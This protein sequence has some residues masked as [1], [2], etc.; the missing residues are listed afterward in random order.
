MKFQLGYFILA[1]HPWQHSLCAGHLHCNSS[2]RDIS[3]LGELRVHVVIVWNRDIDWSEKDV[4][5]TGYSAHVWI[6]RLLFARSR[7]LKHLCAP[8]SPEVPTPPHF[9]LTSTF[10][11]FCPSPSLSLSLPMCLLKWLGKFS[12]W[13]KWKW[14]WRKAEG[15]AATLHRIPS[16]F[17][18]SPFLIFSH[19]S[20]HSPTITLLFPSYLLN[21]SWCNP[22]IKSSSDRN[23]LLSA[24]ITHSYCF[25][26]LHQIRLSFGPKCVRLRFPLPQF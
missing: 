8:V 12:V 23:I 10:F 14:P 11:H 17:F 22:S 19:V 20:L 1:D 26:N 6:P 15:S 7:P 2:E 5:L 25:L 18:F 13:W 21:S 9:C 24:T 4:L 16:C 3:H